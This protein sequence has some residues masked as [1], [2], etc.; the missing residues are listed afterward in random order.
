MYC[1]MTSEK[2]AQPAKHLFYAKV[3]FALMSSF[4]R[5]KNLNVF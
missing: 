2:F 1:T 5:V 4:N 3:P